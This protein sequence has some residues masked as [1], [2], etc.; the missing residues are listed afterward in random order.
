MSRVVQALDSKLEGAPLTYGIRS[1]LVKAIIL[2][3]AAIVLLYIFCLDVLP[4]T[5]PYADPIRSIAASSLLEEHLVETLTFVFL[6]LGGVL[7][8]ALAWRTSK[9]RGKVFVTA[10][11]TVFS[12]SLLF[13]AG[14][15]VAWGQELFFVS[16][17]WYETPSTF[18]EM[19]A[20]GIT[21]LH[22]IYG[23]DG[24]TEVVRVAF[25]IGGLLGVWASSHQ[26][27]REIGAP[28]ILLPS[29]L[30]ITLL[31]GIDLYC[32]YPLVGVTGLSPPPGPGVGLV[33]QLNE[34]NEMIIGMSGCLF[35][36][37]NARMLS[38]SSRSTH[39]RI[40]PRVDA[41][42]LHKPPYTP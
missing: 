31:A 7:G 11:Y 16:S 18:K 9:R 8:L 30:L 37:L 35:V 19:N 38:R 27:F 6:L 12:V 21:T 36:W 14:E 29:F 23:V 26:R 20:Q 13:V 15:E 32:D 40:L 33:N 2:V 34:L 28:V 5:T 3:P 42:E 1:S 4:R 25:G 41:Q 10:F 22:N 39:P 17:Y 24:R